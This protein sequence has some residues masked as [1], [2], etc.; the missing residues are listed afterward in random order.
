MLLNIL[1]G[2]LYNNIDWN[3]L[4]GIVGH[5]FPDTQVT[6]FKEPGVNAF[7]SKDG[8]HKAR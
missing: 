3:A 6:G 4:A 8:G 1:D 2:I 7:L 5:A